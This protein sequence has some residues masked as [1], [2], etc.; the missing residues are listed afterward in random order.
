MTQGPFGT[1][2]TWWEILLIATFVLVVV[3]E[4]GFQIGRRHRSPD[5][6]ATKAQTTL[7]TTALLAL[8]GLLLAFSFSIVEARFGKRKELVLDEANAIGTTYL[9]AGMLPDGEGDRIREL[10][11][12]YTEARVDPRSIRDLRRA[13][14]ESEEVHGE[15]WKEATKA[16]VA[17]PDSEVVS[18]FVQS[19]NDVIDLHESRV[20]VG[21]H[22]RL[23][24]PILF[25]LL[26]ISALSAIAIGFGAG[27]DRRRLPLST[28][29]LL[30]AV[31]SVVV[32]IV[33]LDQPGSAMFRVNQ[34]AMRDALESMEQDQPRHAEAPRDLRP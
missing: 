6:D 34:S 26:A 16:A 15:L 21:L 11:R 28:V 13:I 18:I 7:G 24:L 3:T 22:Q 33:E 32:L 14:S 23:P 8:L 5:I 10:L 29:A 9:R 2:L 20:T 30:F 12:G 1:Q 19:L 27:L 4:V 25:T 17:H 31:A